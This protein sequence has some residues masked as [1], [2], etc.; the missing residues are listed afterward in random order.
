MDTHALV[1]AAASC[2]YGP[3]RLKRSC[4]HSG[5]YAV[6]GGAGQ[7]SLCFEESPAG[8][9]E[10]QLRAAH[11]ISRLHAPSQNTSADRAWSHDVSLPLVNIVGTYYPQTNRWLRL[12]VLAIRRALHLVDNWDEARYNAVAASDGAE[13]AGAGAPLQPWAPPVSPPPM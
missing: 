4:L 13:G 2:R 6:D 10:L 9:A 8:S 11:N 3:E 12:Q 1:S 7:F 5:A